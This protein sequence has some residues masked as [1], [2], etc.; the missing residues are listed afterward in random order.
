MEVDCK[1]GLQPVV[2][3]PAHSLHLGG[4]RVS[5]P[6]LPIPEQPDDEGFQ[7]VRHRSRTDVVDPS[8]AQVK[9]STVVTTNGFDVLG[10]LD[11]DLDY[12]VESDH[13][14]GTLSHPPNV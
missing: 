3:V 14:L 12:P 2:S 9:A 4:E 11:G 7:M 5:N 13:V 10:G 6:I 1:A 8:G